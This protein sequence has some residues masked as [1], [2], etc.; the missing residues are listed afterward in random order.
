MHRQEEDRVD[1][2]ASHVKPQVNSE[3]FTRPTRRYICHCHAAPV[4]LVMLKYRR[5]FWALLGFYLL[6]YFSGKDV[7]E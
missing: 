5:L 7:L 2:W 3:T 6:S 4:V 1:G